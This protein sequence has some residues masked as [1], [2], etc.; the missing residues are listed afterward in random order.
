MRR[1]I[2]RW[3]T[4]RP[5]TISFYENEINGLDYLITQAARRGLRIVFNP[6]PIDES[7]FRLP[8]GRHG[9]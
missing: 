8:L 7:I 3:R 2:G 5:E 6:S 1:S 9:C 4:S